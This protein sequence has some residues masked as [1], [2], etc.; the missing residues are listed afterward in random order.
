MDK[1]HENKNRSI[2]NSQTIIISCVSLVIGGAIGYGISSMNTVS[3]ST[4]NKLSDQ[5]EQLITD[6]GGVSGD[7]LEN[8]STDS[9]AD[10]EIPSNSTSSETDFLEL[11]N[12]TEISYKFIDSTIFE[13]CLNDGVFRCGSDFE[14]GDYYVMALYGAVS[15]YEVS[16]DP[17]NFKSSQYKTIYKI[18]PKSG[19]YV[20]LDDAA[21]L[22]PMNLIDENN[23]KKYGVFLVGK[24]IQEGDYKLEPIT[25]EY[26]S[27][28]SYVT[29]IGAAIQISDQHPADPS[30]KC[31][32]FWDNQTYITLKNGQYVSINNIHMTLVQ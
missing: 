11:N 17:N 21:V 32:Y 8:S 31:D 22:V 10:E 2:L 19:Q 30:S 7:N 27:S 12:A 15:S 4:F 14:P 18:S 23:W 13:G 28:F 26:K 5:Y 16:D 3:V 1:E 29:H 9:D 6:N 25:N 24:D 20:K